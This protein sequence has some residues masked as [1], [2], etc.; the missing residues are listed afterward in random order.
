MLTWLFNNAR[1]SVF[2]VAIFHAST[3][4]AIGYL[5]IMSGSRTLFWLFV[6]L[7]VAAAAIIANDKEFRKSVAD[8]PDISYKWAPGKA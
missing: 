1:G 4:V 6:A 7:Q 8:R 3:D 2:L 5:G